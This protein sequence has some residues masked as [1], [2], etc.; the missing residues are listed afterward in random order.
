MRPD[1]VFE[2]L[3]ETFNEFDAIA[4]K[5]AVYK[6]ETVGD[7]YVASCGCPYRSDTHAAQMADMALDMMEAMTRIRARLNMPELQL[8]IGL[9]SGECVGRCEA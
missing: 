3:E 9:H 7:S 5:R 6:I 2:V 8:R 1:E 4:E